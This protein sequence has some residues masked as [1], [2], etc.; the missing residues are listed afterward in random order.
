[1]KKVETQKTLFQHSLTKLEQN[2]KSLMQK[3]FNF[4]TF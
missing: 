3:C 2:Y 4:A 1:V